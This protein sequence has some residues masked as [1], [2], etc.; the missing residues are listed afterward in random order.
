MKTMQAEGG[1]RGDTSYIHGGPPIRRYA[2]ARLTDEYSLRVNAE[3]VGGRLQRETIPA[4]LIKTT[5]A[6]SGMEKTGAAQGGGD[7]LPAVA[8]GVLSD[9]GLA[10][11]GSPLIGIA[12][13]F[14]LGAALS[15]LLAEA[16]SRYPAPRGQPARGGLS[17]HWYR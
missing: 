17:I 16:G 1:S 15:E 5:I 3:A 8:G 13:G 12:M 7:G 2:T 6:W 4:A 14:C 9:T 10:G 11:R